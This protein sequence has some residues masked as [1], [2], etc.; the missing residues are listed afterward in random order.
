MTEQELCRA[1]VA[2]L[3]RSYSPYS[4]FPVGAALEC[5]DGTVFT[6]CN[7]ENA[8]YGLTHLC[9]THRHLQGHQ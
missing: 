6:G 5:S 1:A 4:H 9:R 8:A 2:M 7:I 3:D